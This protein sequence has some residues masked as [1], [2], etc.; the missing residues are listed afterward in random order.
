M[1]EAG[2]H[3]RLTLFGFSLIASSVVAFLSVVPLNQPQAHY[4]LG[5]ARAKFTDNSGA[6]SQLALA[7]KYGDLPLRFE[8]N[9]GQVPP[10]VKFLARGSNSALFLASTEAILAL[11]IPPQRALQTDRP[12]TRL[13]SHRPGSRTVLL[14]MTLV[15]ANPKAEVLGT[16]R[17]PCLS[18]YF[19]GNDS[20][21]WR[22]GVP[23][24]AKVKYKDIYPGVNLA[25]YGNH[26]RLEYDF[27]AFPGST[28]D[29]IKLRIEGA[30]HL[31][32]ASSGFLV[33]S[34]SAGDVYLERPFV[35]QE[36]N[37]VR[38]R[39]RGDYILAKRDE[40]G[41]RLGR[42][43]VTRPLVIDPVLAYS[44][45]LGGSGGSAAFAVFVDSQGNAYVAGTAQSGFPTTTGVLQPAYGGSGQF[46]TNAFVSKLNPSGDGLL[47]STYLGGTN[48]SGASSPIDATA[49][50]I[51]ADSQGNAYVTGYSNSPD[52]PVVNAFQPTLKSAA[53]NAFVAKLNATGTAL[54]YSTYLGGSGSEVA[55]GIAVDS[56]GHAYVAGSTSSMD[57]PVVNAFQSSA[58]NS[59]GTAF[60]TKFGIDGSSLI[61]STYLGGSN[62]DT[63]SAIA[64]DSTGNTYVVGATSSTDFPTTSGAFQPV[65]K[66][67]QNVQNAFFTKLNP[68]GSNLLYSTFLGGSQL[69]TTSATALALD[70]RS[71]VYVVGWTAASFSAASDFPT[72]PGVI[73]P[74]LPSGDGADFVSKINP[75]GQGTS[76]LVYSTFLGGDN[77]K[78]A[79]DL[80]SGVIVDANGDAVITGRT[81]SSNFPTT[82]GAFQL[83]LKSPP[84]GFN[85]V[86]S[87]LNPT[88]TALLYSTYLGGSVSDQGLGIAADLTGSV[89]VVGQSLSPDFPTT[90]GAFQPNHLAPSGAQDAF[91]AKLAI[92]SVITVAPSFVDFGNQLLNQQSS[93]QVVTITNNS[94]APVTFSTSPSLT[95]PDASEF[96]STSDCGADLPPNANC[97]VTLNF[98]PTTLGAD[99]ADL[100]LF[101]SDPS[102]PQIVPI[103]GT[104]TVD[105]SISA[106]SSETVLAGSSVQIPVTVTPLAESTQTVSL[107]CTGAP[108]NATCTVTPTSVTLD[109]THSSAATAT[110]QTSA[111]LPF[112]LPHNRIPRNSSDR[113]PLALL[114]LA[115]IAGLLKAKQ[116]ATSLAF[117]V[118]IVGCLVFIG[119]GGGSSGNTSTPKGTT[120]LVITGKSGS[121]TH[122]ASISL[123][124]D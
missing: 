115:F 66:A 111:A 35:Y 61:Y 116:R 103:T 96:T 122:S 120:T 77:P 50:G 42:Y 101:D 29:R 7:E 57:F 39:V 97:D 68:V 93:S 38:E 79:G 113:L 124:V 65:S 73:Q 56:T 1:V 27:V 6:S 19:I 105:F 9:L 31:R 60:V 63:A 78:G 119:C 99:N 20:A 11:D 86:V 102:S 95:G 34:T 94:S 64:V 92:N 80:A 108:T 88:A 4:E 15:S 106:P 16:N 17:L 67:S 2:W 72:T 71:E 53:G 43:D 21:K 54:T 121:Q 114:F 47:Y 58:R 74:T 40:V 112:G 33:M 8:A 117:G 51:V 37:G 18:N 59:F 118:V 82:P 14:R 48:P 69:T 110:V 81:T 90:A 10:E 100:A 91:V 87:K 62:A 55:D 30:E 22:T 85:A 76:D 32:I 83:T 24:Y 49:F 52:F 25:F 104:G 28:P 70:P 44:T 123:T 98:T 41:F 23:N 13:T 107:S 5:F 12:R 84:G 45:F 89:Y 46:D 36:K 109:G 75:A 26:D 3:A